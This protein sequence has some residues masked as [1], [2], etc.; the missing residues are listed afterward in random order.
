MSLTWPL[1]FFAYPLEDSFSAVTY[2]L[3][4]LTLPLRTIPL[5]S[6]MLLVTLD[7]DHGQGQQTQLLRAP[8][9][10]FVQTI[11]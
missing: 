1:I 11:G 8:L 2:S 3:P 6:V 9:P 4:M 5:G 7:F 10:C